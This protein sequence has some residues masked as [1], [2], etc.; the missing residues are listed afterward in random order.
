VRLTDQEAMHRALSLALEGRRGAFPNPM[1]GAVVLRGGEVV[2]EGH[3]A[4]CGGPHA[5]VVALERAG[6]AARGA[7]M[8]VTLEP[9]CHQG[10]TGPCARAIV[11]AGI[12]R[13]VAAMSDPDSRVAG[14][15]FESLRASG[16]VVEVG[17]LEDEARSLNRIYLHFLS[18]GRSHVRLK[19]AVTLDGRVA[20]PDGSSRWITGPAARQRVHGYRADADAVMIGAGTART[21]DPS[22]LPGRVRIV[23][24]SHAGLPPGLVLFDGRAPLIVAVPAGTPDPVTAGLDAAG[25][26]VWEI[27]AAGDGVDLAALL[28]RTAL[29]GFGAVLCEGGPR[30]A[31]SL[32]S[33]DLADVASIF[34]APAFLGSEGVPAL[35]GLRGSGIADATR[36][37]GVRYEVL[38]EDV[39]VEGGFVHRTG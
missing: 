4:C 12:S 39:L 10:R 16:V 35:S 29:E 14:G 37:T 22:L 5:E 26:V 28:R 34:V 9:C 6:T 17:L 23:V 18:T 7:T 36:L 3:H 21:D 25:A 11:E 30:L 32:V 31:A 2:G 38:G 20:A 19:L 33:D 1:V 8:F 27:P 15:G 13:V 24:S